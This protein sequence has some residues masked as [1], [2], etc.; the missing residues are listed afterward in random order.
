MNKEPMN[1]LKAALLSFPDGSIDIRES[2]P[3]ARH[4][5]FRIGGNADLFLT[6]K[7]LD[8]AVR[9]FSLLADLHLPYRV[10]GNASNLLIADEGYR[11]VIVYTGELCEVTVSGT[12]LMALCGA[13]L[14]RCARAAAK[15]SLSGLEKLSGIPGTVGGALAMN[16]GAYEK[17]IASL[18]SSVLV[19]DVEKRAC[20]TL[21]ASELAF[22]YRHSIISDQKLIALQCELSMS[23]RERCEIFAEMGTLAEKRRRAQP[24]ELPS[25][26]SVFKRPPNDYA[27]RLIESAGLKGT[28]IGGAEISRKHA[29]FIVNVGGAS[30]H[31]VLALIALIKTEV[32]KKS[33]VLLVCEIEYV[34]SGEKE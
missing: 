14:A 6:P 22:G 34:N 33:D 25:A 11:G 26:G 2:E 27:G 10:I 31:D 7:T 15:A 32:Q 1:A 24:L 28:R 30:A 29:G 12:S 5:T 20:R 3:M 16:A 8:V 19:Y 21:S 9:L 13:T 4:T 18:V 17:D 23:E